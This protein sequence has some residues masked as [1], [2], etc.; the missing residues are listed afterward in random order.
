MEKQLLKEIIYDQREQLKAKKEGVKREALHGLLKRF[1][2]LPHAIV[3]AGI[4]RSG[5]STLLCQ[6]MNALDAKGYYFNFEDERLIHFEVADFQKLYEALAELEGER[7]I[8]FFDE[9]QNVGGWERFVRRMHDQGYKFFLTGSNASLLSRELGTKLTGRHISITLYPFSF[10]EYLRFHDYQPKKDDLYSTKRRVELKRYFDRYLQEG[11]MPEYLQ[12]RTKESLKKVY[13]DI[14]YRD[15]IVR[16]DLKESKS[17]RELS[18]YFISNIAAPFSYNKLK[19]FLQLGSVNTVKS[20]LEYLENSFLFFSISRFSHSLKQQSVS[21]KKIYCIDNGLAQNIAF[22]FSENKGKF[23]E[24][25]VFLEL[26]R[27]RKEVY[28]YKTKDGFEV[29]FAIKEGREIKK[30]IQVAW[31]LEK[32]DVK[33]RELRALSAAMKELRVNKS[34]I[35]TDD[36]EETVRFEK[37]T[38]K[39]LPVYKW[40][41]EGAGG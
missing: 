6:I 17:L 25:L 14:L 37:K 10:A 12:Y 4:R 27:R 2:V 40:L 30:L 8:F 41:M 35:L 7:R 15:I 22:A 21:P 19:I 31:S 28:Y 1:A 26:Q 20:Y 24:N 29:D 11:G 16:Y 5:K 34:L 18:L 33:E 38:I 39:A 32:A 36:Y 3:I 9:I 23:L 13:D